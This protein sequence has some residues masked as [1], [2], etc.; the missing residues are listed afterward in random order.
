MDG[1]KASN[2]TRVSKRS[3]TN[4]ARAYPWGMQTIGSDNGVSGTMPVVYAPTVDIEDVKAIRGG[5][6]LGEESANS[7]RFR[8]PLIWT[9]SNVLSVQLKLRDQAF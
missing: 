7:T 5:C 2:S 4:L 6:F 8:T 3:L 1:G 9:G